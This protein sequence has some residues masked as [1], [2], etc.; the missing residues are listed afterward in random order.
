MVAQYTYDPYGNMTISGSSSNPYQY[1]GR[2]NDGT[3]VYYYRARYYSRQF[4]RFIS[5]DPAGLLFGPDVYQYTYDSPT[6]YF[7]PSGLAPIDYILPDWLANHINWNYVPAICSADS[8]R[9]YGGGGGSENIQGG[10]YQ[11][12]V[13]H[14]ANK[15][16]SWQAD[17]ME[18]DTLYEAFGEH[19]GGGVVMHGR[20][21]KEALLFP[22]SPYHPKFNRRFG[23]VKV[24]AEAGLGP[25]IGY[26]T[27]GIS[28]GFY[29]DV[30]L[31]GAVGNYGGGFGFGGG[32]SVTFS[33]AASCVAQ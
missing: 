3:G 30:G 21:P 27:D 28:I 12:D 8:F 9:F 24:R 25:L 4:G 22:P 6:N 29:G 19:W 18:S 26:S 11:L 2:E 14:Y 15:G 7:D 23:P 32:W 10:A 31:G 13:V 17:G 16:G 5:E 33:S 1:T 20:K